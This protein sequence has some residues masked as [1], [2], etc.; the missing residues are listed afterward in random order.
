[1]FRHMLRP[2]E[3]PESRLIGWVGA[4][5]DVSPVVGGPPST[6]WVLL[7]AGMVLGL[8]IY[9]LSLPVWV[10]LDARMRG[11]REWVW[12]VFV[13]IGN[14]MALLTYILAR[15]PRPRHSMPS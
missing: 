9:W 11:E 12:A 10:W 3:S 4:T 2:V 6:T 5:Y 15:R 7:L 13:L 1:M 8:G 14:L